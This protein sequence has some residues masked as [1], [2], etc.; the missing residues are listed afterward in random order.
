MDHTRNI[1]NCWCSKAIYCHLVIMPESTWAS[2]PFKL[3]T[4]PSN[5]DKWDTLCIQLVLFEAIWLIIRSSIATTVTVAV[6]VMMKMMYCVPQ[7]RN[8][9]QT[10]FYL[11]FEPCRYFSKS[12]TEVSR[13]SASVMW[14]TKAKSPWPINP[15]TLADCLFHN[16][17]C[18]SQ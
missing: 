12:T 14:D 7:A 10:A 5:L 15:H 16:S 6:M 13:L 1:S 8:T 17:V 9:A 18:Q 11:H 2:L 3:P 4:C